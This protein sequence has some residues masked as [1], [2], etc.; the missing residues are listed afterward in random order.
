MCCRLLSLYESEII[1]IVQRNQYPVSS[2]DINQLSETQRNSSFTAA[3]QQLEEVLV[4]RSLFSCSLLRGA[5]EMGLRKAVKPEFGGGTRSFSCEEDYIYENIES[6]LCF[7]TSQVSD[8]RHT[9]E[10]LNGNKET[11]R[12]SCRPLQERQSIIKYWLDNLRAKHGEVLHNISFLE[13]QPIS[14]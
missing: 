13:G 2:I 4:L 5:E 10:G 12:L 1:N 14:E 3:L 6:E 7:F 9:R 11:H 8:R